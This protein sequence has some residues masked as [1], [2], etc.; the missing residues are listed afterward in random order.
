MAASSPLVFAE[1]AQVGLL[2][3]AWTGGALAFGTVYLYTNDIVPTPASQTADFTPSGGVS[4]PQAIFPDIPA[5]TDGIWA[6]KYSNLR[7]AFD[8]S[9]APVLIYGWFALDDAGNYLAGC[10]FDDAPIPLVISQD[11][12]FCFIDFTLGGGFS[13]RDSSR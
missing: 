1:S 2:T 3:A 7:F 5:R 4:A 8:A 11:T 9:V 12:V 10:R 13:T 6:F